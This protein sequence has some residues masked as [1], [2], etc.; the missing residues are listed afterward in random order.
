M[1]S[2]VGSQS[3][4]LINLVSPVMA[5]SKVQVAAVGKIDVVL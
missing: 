2:L 5:K 1:I 4:A 3:R